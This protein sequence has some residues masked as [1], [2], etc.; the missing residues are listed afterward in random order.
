[1]GIPGF[2]VRGQRPTATQHF[3]P[4]DIPVGSRIAL[5]DDYSSTFCCSYRRVLSVVIIRVAPRTY[6]HF[7][8][9][10]SAFYIDPTKMKKKSYS[11]AGL[12]KLFQLGT[13]RIFVVVV[14]L[15]FRSSTA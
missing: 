2:T 7:F 1:M 10:A 5:H 4:L 6:F 12:V 14:N 11:L 3:F 15:K 8:I 13:R 9:I